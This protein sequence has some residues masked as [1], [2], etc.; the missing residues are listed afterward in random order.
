MHE[1]QSSHCSY[2]NRPSWMFHSHDGGN[3]ESL[4][5]QFRHNND[6]KR[7]NE[8]MEEASGSAGKSRFAA[9]VFFRF[10]LFMN[11]EVGMEVDDLITRVDGRDFG[12]GVTVGQ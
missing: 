3:E 9:A 8:T 12:L 7:C 1:C 4:V 2:K 6:T 11:F 10:N 5:A